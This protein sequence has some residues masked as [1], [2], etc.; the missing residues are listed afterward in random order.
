MNEIRRGDIYYIHKG[1]ETTGSEIIA[2]RP[3]IVVSND[4]ANKYSNVVEIVFCTTKEKPCLPTHVAINSTKYK[5]TALCE[6]ITSVSKKRIGDYIG[7][8][9]KSEMKTIDRKL[10]ISLDLC[11]PNSEESPNPDYKPPMKNQNA[12][13]QPASEFTIRFAIKGIIS[14]KIS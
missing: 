4:M 14:H 3:G 2:G 11:S 5:S 10:A 7:R 12:N 8:C 9:S 6:Q 13:E 1:P